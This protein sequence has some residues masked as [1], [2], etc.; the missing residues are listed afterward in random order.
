MHQMIE[1][2]ADFLLRQELLTERDKPWCIYAIER[3][4]LTFLSFSVL[5]LAGS[6]SSGF[7]NAFCFVAPVLWLRKR[8]SG[9]HASTPLRCLLL[10]LVITC[11]ALGVFLPYMHQGAFFAVQ[12]LSLAIIWKLAPIRHK[13]L[14][15]NQEEL[16]ANRLCARKRL[17]LAVALSCILLLAGQLT[18]AYSLSLGTAMVACSLAAAKIAKQEER[19]V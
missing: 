8:T 17:V 5:L 12:A 15:F 7:G 16:A 6:Y 9:Y 13:S 14:H 2:F 11:L 19:V 18:A 10:S 4:I 1:H 3:H